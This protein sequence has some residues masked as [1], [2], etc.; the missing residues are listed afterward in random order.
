MGFSTIL[1]ELFN[2]EGSLG[3]EY[4]W[5]LCSKTLHTIHI[6]YYHFYSCFFFKLQNNSYPDKIMFS[7]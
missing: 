2:A 1:K 3:S 4:Y 6:A 7:Q 5:D